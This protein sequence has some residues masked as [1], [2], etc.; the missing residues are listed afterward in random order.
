MSGDAHLPLW[1]AVA[2]A[3][4]KADAESVKARGFH[5]ITIG[6]LSV[7]A[8]YDGEAPLPL[9]KLLTGT[10]PE[11]ARQ[12]LAEG[13]SPSPVGISVNAFVVKI[14]EQRLL[15]DS[16]AGTNFGTACGRLAVT[17]KA[18][19]CPPES[20]TSILLT[21]IHPDHTGGL[22]DEN[23]IVFPNAKVYVNRIDIDYWFNPAEKDKATGKRKKMFEEGTAG[24]TPYFQSGHVATFEGGD[25]I[26][27]N[28]RTIAAPG[29]TAGHTMYRV[30]SD[31]NSI[32]FFGDLVH[33][34]ELQMLDPSVAIQLDSDEAQAVETRQTWL[35]RFADDGTLT[36]G[37]HTFFPGF[38]HVVRNGSS[39]AW[40]PQQIRP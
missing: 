1:L 9:D 13:Q 20:I 30:E 27:Q 40:K 10:S 28:V 22:A 12:H 25:E 38:G 33:S 17:L 21:H 39:F 6:S 2:T 26:L 16:G 35:P 23:G 24:V 7:I 19:G 11:E 14:G 34:A 31:G 37:A 36:A 4:A 29:H 15:I 18:S 3:G 8:I 5:E 32:V